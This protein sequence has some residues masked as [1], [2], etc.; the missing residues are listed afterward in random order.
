MA[1]RPLPAPSRGDRR[2]Q[3]LLPNYAILGALLV[4]ALGPLLV[5]TFNSL[6]DRAEL[7]ANPLGPPRTLV[8]ENFATAWDVGNFSVTTRN[9]GLLVA[10]TVFGVLFLGGLAAYSLAKLNLPGAGLLTLYLLIGTSLPIQLY[11][12]PLFFAWQRL[13]LVNN[14]FGLVLIYIATNAPFAVFLLRSYMLQI[15]TD[16]EDAA[17]V[18]GASEWQVF[19]R[20]VVPLSWPGFLTVGLVVALN[21]WNEFLLATVF[22]TEQHLFTVVTSYAN[23]ATRFSRD[24]SLTSAAA[25]MMILPIIAIFLLLQRRFIEGLTQ[26]GLKG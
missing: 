4:F 19:A 10:G 5:L 6:K 12:V 9:S 17:R 13:G 11:L 26:G 2:E 23:F 25:L 14:L 8:F 22:L 18:D 1:T 24:W 15:P 21:V 7:G 20:I 16:F 3:S